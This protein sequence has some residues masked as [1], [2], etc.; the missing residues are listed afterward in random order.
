MLKTKNTNR[1]IIINKETNEVEE[2]RD[3][4]ILSE[5]IGVPLSTL[6]SWFRRDDKTGRFPKIARFKNYEIYKVKHVY[7]RDNTKL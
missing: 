3:F 7:T 6:K 2:F 4:S 1:V 5:F